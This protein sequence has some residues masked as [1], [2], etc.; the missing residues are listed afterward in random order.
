MTTTPDRNAAADVL[1]AM[2]RY[3]SNPQQS[4]AL[5]LAI[6]LLRAG[7]EPVAWMV[8]AET[9]GAVSAEMTEATADLV[10]AN[11]TREYGNAY[12]KITKRP[13]YAA[14]SPAAAQP[15][16]AGGGEAWDCCGCGMQQSPRAGSCNRCGAD[17]PA[18][19]VVSEAMVDRDR[20]ADIAFDAWRDTPAEPFP[21]TQH[22]KWLAVVD[23]LLAALNAPPAADGMVVPRSNDGKEQVAFEEWARGQGYAMDTHPIHWLFL[24]SRTAAARDGWRSA[25]DYVTQSLA[26]ARGQEDAARY[27]WLRE[28]VASIQAGVSRRG[29]PINMCSVEARFI[30]ADTLDAAIDAARQQEN[31]HA[32]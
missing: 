7:G 12:G 26:A 24:D 13:L 29:W 1:A 27:R 5:D 22:P 31:D 20:L 10:I 4:A 23:A 11:V 30:D 28:N 2:W 8:E 19:G 32:K 16:R 15:E 3:N 18:P 9:A 6:R 25:L 17:R 14:P 21:G